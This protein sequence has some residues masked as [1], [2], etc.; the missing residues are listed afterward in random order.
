LP[1]DPRHLVA[2]EFDDGARYLDLG[3]AVA[4]PSYAVVAR[5]QSALALHTGQQSFVGLADEA[6]GAPA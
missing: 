3:H 4:V 5:A 2:V 6:I 1:D